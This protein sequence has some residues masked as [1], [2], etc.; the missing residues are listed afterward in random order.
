MKIRKLLLVALLITAIYLVFRKK[1]NDNKGTPAPLE[2]QPDTLVPDISAPLVDIE[3][4]IV[5]P[6]ATPPIS[7]NKPLTVIE[8]PTI[9]NPIIKQPIV[10]E[11]IVEEPIILPLE[12]KLIIIEPLPPKIDRHP[13]ELL[14]LNVQ[15]SNANAK[16][17]NQNILIKQDLQTL[18]YL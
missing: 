9:E 17:L 10:W 12:N 18:A 8:F 16:E 4:P 2:K 6:V 5:P 15:I 1:Q 11:P 7:G 13:T 14:D 3:T